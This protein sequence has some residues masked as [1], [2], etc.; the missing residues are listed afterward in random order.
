MWYMFK[1]PNYNNKD[2][3]TSNDGEWTSKYTKCFWSKPTDKKVSS[4]DI[5][6]NW[7]HH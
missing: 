5:V 3:C 4:C 6:T 2:D 1:M 7:L